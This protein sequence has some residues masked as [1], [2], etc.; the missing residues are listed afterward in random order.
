M[1]KV[2]SLFKTPQEAC[3]EILQVLR[4]SNLNFLVSES[5]Y[6]VQICLRKRFLKD[7]P[8]PIKKDS[9]C[10]NNLAAKIQA[11]EDENKILKEI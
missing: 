5:P 10:E 6:S 1:A 7:T 4:C 8:R 2:Q 9:S 11:L 3:N